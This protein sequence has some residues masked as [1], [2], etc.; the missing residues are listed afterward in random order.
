[1]RKRK[2]E[3]A[4]VWLSAF[5][6]LGICLYGTGKLNWEAGKNLLQETEKNGISAFLQQQSNQWFPVTAY[7]NGKTG[8][9]SLLETTGQILCREL[10]PAAEFCQNY[11][12]DVSE[13]LP[14]S[15]AVPDSFLEQEEEKE[16]T[17]E[18]TDNTREETPTGSKT[19][20]KKQLKDYQFLIKNFYIVDSTTSVAS[21]ELDGVK[22]STMDLT[23]DLTGQDPKILI[24]HTHGSED[25]K[26]S[27]SGKK[28]DTIIGAGDTLTKILEDTY[29]IKVYHDRSTYDTINGVLDRSKAYTYAGNNVT[30][31][32][33]K[34]PSIEVVIDLHRDAVSEGKHLVTEINGKQTAQIMFFNGMSR[35]AKNGDI[36]YLQNPNKESNLAFS[37]QMQLAAA[38]L[39]PGFTR[40]IY[41]K[42]YRYNLHLKPRSLLIEAG[43]QTNTVEEVKNAME[44]LAA[45]LYQVLSG[46][47]ED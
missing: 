21:G 18:E 11:W 12:E 32:L 9:D 33:K 15:D 27:R 7:E 40:K 26:D 43:A 19:Y 8:L 29:N 10:I 4:V 22:L 23:M 24:Y 25:F 46:N 14:I 20:T 37:L 38:K 2:W 44:P 41:L 16:E 28:A 39:F 42:G 35:T 45:L 5:F 1:M 36:A 31:L 13:A 30:R 34:Y 47:S 6:I 3:R 17:T